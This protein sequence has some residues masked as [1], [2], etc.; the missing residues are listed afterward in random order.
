MLCKLTK[1]E[2]LE[3]LMFSYESFFA[4]SLLHWELKTDK[5]WELFSI[6][7]YSIIFS[8]DECLASGGLKW[9]IDSDNVDL[10]ESNADVNKENLGPSIR[11]W[12][13]DQK[14]KNI[15][16]NKADDMINKWRNE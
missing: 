5:H 12:E 6:E 9:F 2:I 15:K 13:N 10:D 8:F 11:L 3:I 7:L 14:I 1:P 16:G 4:E